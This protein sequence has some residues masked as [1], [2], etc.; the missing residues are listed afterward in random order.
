MYRYV[1]TE[2]HV[3]AE[4]AVYFILLPII[5]RSIVGWLFG[6]LIFHVRRTTCIKFRL[7]RIQVVSI[8]VGSLIK[9]IDFLRRAN[10]AN[11]VVRAGERKQQEN[12]HGGGSPDPLYTSCLRVP[13]N[14]LVTAKQ[15]P[16]ASGCSISR[17]C[18]F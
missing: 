4:I 14:V 7:I 15:S 12:G 11:L 16:M 17:T 5:F 13:S 9:P 1:F 10:G 8:P 2:S 6:A 18:A 3:W